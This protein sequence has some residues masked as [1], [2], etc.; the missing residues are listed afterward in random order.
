MYKKCSGLKKI[1]KYY[2]FTQI[3]NKYVLLLLIVHFSQVQVAAF[4]NNLDLR[5]VD[6]S[7]NPNLH[8]VKP[9]AFPQILQ[10]SHLSLANTSIVTLRQGDASLK[11]E[12]MNSQSK[13]LYCPS[14]NRSDAVPW[15]RLGSLSIVI[16]F[17]T[18]LCT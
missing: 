15:E 1:T 3:D 9:F 10:L 11:F 18:R 17:S 16:L 5:V 4:H 14:L 8:E 6:L 7:N 2:F 13:A 12:L